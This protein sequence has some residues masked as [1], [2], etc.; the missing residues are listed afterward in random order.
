MESRKKPMPIP[1]SSER[2][3]DRDVG[4]TDPAI[5]RFASDDE[6]WQAVCER[7]AAAGGAFVYGVRTTG[8][9][10]RPACSSRRPRRAN[11]VFFDSLPAAERAGF[12]PCKRCHAGRLAS[13][14]ALAIAA[15]CEL[16]S[17]EDAGGSVA[18]V[19]EAV[20]MT[21]ASLSR[22]FRTRLGVTP[23][24][25][26]RRVLADRARDALAASS[27]VTEAIYAAGYSASSRYYDSAGRELGMTPREARRGGA[28]REV[29][30]TTR[31]TS[32]GVLGIAWTERGVSDVF[33][34]DDPALLDATV[35]TRWPQAR[36]AR[37]NLPRWLDDV[38]V[39]VE[40]P[41]VVDLPL[42]IQGTAFQQRVW[43]E[44]R[45]IP[46]GQTRTYSEVATSIGAPQSPRAVARAIGQN[47]LAVVVPCHRVVA[48]N[49]ALSGY[50]WGVSRKAELLRREK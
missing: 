19:A 24:Q 45:S 11:V 16:L 39:A 10:C 17:A 15:A 23:L 30:Y 43:Q 12:R 21:P 28:G 36:R 35:R 1:A 48:K 46:V 29:R 31:P 22:S 8:V 40:R 49:G 44:L 33:F 9:V 4:R 38:V 27:T 42:D 50:R 37:A 25:Y 18:A 7:N 32:L 34:L 2:P 6:R 41:V 20:G 14:P 13:D 47:P 3:T 5:S 26:R